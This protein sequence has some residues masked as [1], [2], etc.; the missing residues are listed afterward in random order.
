MNILI[1]FLAVFALAIGQVL[2]DPPRLEHRE[3]ID[4]TLPGIECRE[5]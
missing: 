1:L 3:P 5:S 2:P 4:C